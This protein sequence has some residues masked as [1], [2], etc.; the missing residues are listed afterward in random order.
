MKNEKFTQ[1]VEIV[2]ALHEDMKPVYVEITNLNKVLEN[3]DKD[4][5][6]T[7]NPLNALILR[8]TR[9]AR[10]HNLDNKVML[11][12]DTDN[13]E[14]N[15]YTIGTNHQGLGYEGDYSSQLTPIIL[16]NRHYNDKM[17]EQRLRD[18][19]FND[20]SVIEL[21]SIIKKSNQK[22]FLKIIK[23]MK[24]YNLIEA[25]EVFKEG[26]IKKV[27]IPYQDSDFK[28]VLDLNKSYQ[29]KF[30]IKD[31]KE[32]KEFSFG[33]DNNN[34]ENPSPFVAN[35]NDDLLTNPRTTRKY[36]NVN[37]IELR[38]GIIIS[39]YK[40]ELIK[41]IQGKAILL[42]SV[43]KNYKAEYKELNEMLQPLLALEKL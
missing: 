40:D 14:M 17:D 25:F 22:I 30:S 18:I 19:L 31:L 34:D 2:E 5:S 11:R 9:T 37:L 39:Q 43:V 1:V 36:A 41:A 7:L 16:S 13:D 4:I 27:E 35:D 26:N 29:T 32:E 12:K 8:L 6:T 24:K 10:R 3:L 33:V 23:A 38:T 42:N 15:S 28:I 20:D 21:A